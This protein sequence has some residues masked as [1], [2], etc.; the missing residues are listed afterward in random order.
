MSDFTVSNTFLVT[1]IRV[2]AGIKHLLHCISGT[3]LYLTVIRLQLY[4]VNRV[5]HY[6]RELFLKLFPLQLNLGGGGVEDQFHFVLDGP[7]LIA[8]AILLWR[9]WNKPWQSALCLS[10]WSQQAHLY[11]MGMLRF[12]LSLFDINQLSLPTP[13]ILFLSL[14]LSLW[15]FQLYF[16]P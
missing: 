7:N 5:D 16:I 13:F 9:Y 10:S 12:M 15:P 3:L 11:V 8:E 4:L 1:Q 2:L 6:T 14:I